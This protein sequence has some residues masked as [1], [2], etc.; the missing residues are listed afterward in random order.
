MST[1]IG[2]YKAGEI[3]APIV[4]TF[5]DSAGQPLQLT[6][7]TALWVF[8]HEE[9]TPVERTASLYTDGTDGKIVYTWQDGDM[10]LSGNYQAE[11][12]VGN[13]ANRF[14]SVTYVYTVEDAVA[15]PI[16]NI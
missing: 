11:A 13:N 6:G 15:N 16:P 4:V 12:W 3:P 7:Y 9:D 10:A 8:Q 5:K 1:Q 2:P 14:A